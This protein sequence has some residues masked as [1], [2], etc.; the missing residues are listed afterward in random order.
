M[1]TDEQ[2]L[3][4]VDE[5]LKRSE[6][7]YGAYRFKYTNV[8]RTHYD[9][10]Y[11]IVKIVRFEI[12]RFPSCSHHITFDELVTVKTAIE[13]VES[14]LSQPLTQ[15]YIDKIARGG[16][17]HDLD[18]IMSC[19]YRGQCL[20]DAKFLAVMSIKYGVLTFSCDS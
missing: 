13:K 1:L 20:S 11:K 19:K 2:Q 17:A 9:D 7:V 18:F 10:V 3:T 8:L 5:L 12:N 14:Y 16:D 15:D 6:E 4:F